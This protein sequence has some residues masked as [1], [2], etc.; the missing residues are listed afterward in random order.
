MDARLLEAAAAP[1]P[2]PAPPVI[3]RVRGPGTCAC[4]GSQVDGH[5]LRDRGGFVCSHFR[6]HRLSLPAVPRV[7][8]TRLS[9]LHHR[10]ERNES[11]PAAPLISWSRGK[12]LCKEGFIAVY[13][14]TIVD[15]PLEARHVARWVLNRP[16]LLGGREVYDDSELVFNYCNAFEPYIKNRIDGKLYMPTID[17]E[18]F[19][20]DE[21]DHTPRGLECFYIG[22]STWKEGY[23][24]PT[25]AFEITRGTPAKKELGKLFRA[26]RMLY[27]FDNSTILAYEAI[28]CGCPVTIIP[29]G[30]QSREDYERLELGM[31]GIAWGMEERDQV[32]VDVAKLRAPRQDQGRLPQGSHTLHRP[33][34]A[35]GHH[36]GARQLQ[37][38]APR[39]ASCRPPAGSRGA[40]DRQPEQPSRRSG[41]VRGR[42]SARGVKSSSTLRDELGHS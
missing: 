11:R 20:C 7:E 8:R 13:P 40:G 26:S 22:K 33:D 32:Q 1:P 41:D 5:R 16:G 19:F 10:F 31:D 34:A 6:G 2:Q 21:N 28:L 18:I 37:R 30:T 3:T 27:C 23:I 36:Q 12:S 38:L 24:D 25:Q 39:N 14:E 42:A 4:A 15:N 35:R 17:E 29:D 9:L